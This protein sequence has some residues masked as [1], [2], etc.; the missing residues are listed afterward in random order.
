VQSTAGGIP[1]W[2]AAL[3]WR[4]RWYLPAAITLYVLTTSCRSCRRRRRHFKAYAALSRRGWLGL[5]QAEFF[6]PVL[7][8]ALPFLRLIRSENRDDLG[9]VFVVNCL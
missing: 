9:V 5:R 4:W 6:F 2:A 7:L 3:G 1:T 8:H